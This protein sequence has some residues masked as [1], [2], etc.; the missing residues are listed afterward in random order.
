MN[1]LVSVI[2]PCF[3]SATTVSETLD[4]VLKQTYKNI[5][6]IIVNDG[7]Q[8]NIFE[9]IEPYLS[10]NRNIIYH[11]QQNKGL[12]GARNSGIALSKGNYILCLDSDDLIAFSYIE[13]CVK[14]LDSQPK[15]KLVYSNGYFFEAENGKWKF[16]KYSFRNL[17]LGNSIHA[18]A[19]MRKSDFLK[20]G[21]YDESLAIYEDWN[22]WINILKDEGGVVLIEEPLFFCRKRENKSSLS[23]FRNQNL[24]FEKQNRRKVYQNNKEIYTRIIG[25]PID[26]IE[27]IR[28]L[29][30]IKARDIRR[31]ARLGNRIWYWLFRRNK[32][33]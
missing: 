5:E 15:T 26:M 16:P 21:P 1:N 25:E 31:K 24:E 18:S 4:S 32:K 23:D 27:T 30:L 20:N 7:S 29:E 13:R 19:M 33:K 28:E 11:S 9:V 14:V 10:Q 8:D 3:N 12:S 2:I 22:L 6:I 17:L